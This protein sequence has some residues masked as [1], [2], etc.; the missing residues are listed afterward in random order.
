MRRLFTNLGLLQIFFSLLLV[1][2]V[3]FTALYFVYKNSISEIYDKIS[4]NNALVTK[5]IVQS[6]D[7]SFITV[8]NLIYSI[9]SLSPRDRLS[10]SVDGKIDMSQVYTMVEHIS[11]LVATI[12]FIEE[13]AVFYNDADLVITSSG[14]SSLQHFFNNKYRHSVFNANYWKNYAGGKKSFRIFPA[15]D[16]RVYSESNQQQRVKKLMIAVNGNKVYMTNKNILILIDVEALMQHVNLTA[17]IPGA[18]LIILDQ[19]RNVIHSTDSKFNLLDVLNDVYFGNEQEATLT[20]ENYEYNFYKSDYN[21]F[22]YIDKVPYQFQ[23]IDSVAKANYMIILTAIVSA[24]IL[25]LVLSIYLY[26]PVKNILGLL[27]SGNVRG[28][29]FR[30]IYSGVLKIQRE[31]ETYK[32]Q[33]DNAEDKI[34]KTVVLQAL[35]ESSNVAEHDVLLRRYMPEFYTAPHFVL[36]LWQVK[37]RRNEAD[38]ARTVDDIANIL[39]R[40]LKHEEITAS[41]FHAGNDQFIAMIGLQHPNVRVRIV[42]GLQALAVKL[43]NEELSDYQIAAYVSKL[44]AAEMEYC[45]RAY[46][47]VK[48]GM[49]YRQVNETAAVID[50][51][52]L[53]FDWNIYFPLEQMEKLSNCLLRGEEA[54]SSQLIKEMIMENKERNVHQHQLVHIVKTIF[55][56]MMRHTGNRSDK[57]RELTQLESRFF[58]LLSETA[59]VEALER[60]LLEVA[61]HLARESRQEKQNKLNPA[62]I[63]QYIELHYM[64]SMHLDHIAEVVGTSA[65]YFSRYFRKT[66]GVNYIEYLNKVRLSHAKELLKDTHLSIAEIGEKTGYLNTSTFSATFRKYFGISPS[67]Y[68][69]QLHQ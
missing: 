2:A 48:N 69:S 58:Q 12:D 36:V 20:K 41:V 50:V 7:N 3:M 26:N 49:A 23:N 30:K 51:E 42:K 8:N 65:K 29:D 59:D 62:F 64:E 13:V 33:L 52:R 54:E 25:A 15:E 17:M 57:N 19:N 24:I 32:Q 5:S 61:K 66:F 67:E 40:S 14:T 68:R 1:I 43:E 37:V 35:D 21:D 44:Y 16:F 10:S 34:R 47:D 46:R 56:Y 4:Q 6:F 22:I 38:D 11:T 55:F 31:S 39:E 18:S 28:N 63:S 9:Q 53:E 60:A 45:S 27:G